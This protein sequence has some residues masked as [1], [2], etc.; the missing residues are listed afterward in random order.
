MSI[1]GSLFTA[2][3]GMS[4]QSQSLS[5][6]SDNIANA[7]T[8]GY[9]RNDA[10]FS[11]LVTNAGSATLYSSGGV[12][13]RANARIS[14]QG[15]LQQSASASDIAISGN[16]MFTVRN[17]TTD[18]NSE[19]V[20]T[21]AGSFSPDKNGQLK[22]T[23]GYYLYGWPTQPDGT[24]TV[25]E[26]AG[27][28]VPV[29]LSTLGTTSQVT[30]NAS[31]KANLDATIAGAAYPLPG[32]TAASW[33]H[34][35]TVYDSLGTPQTLRADFTKVKSPTATANGTANLSGAGGT[36]ATPVSINVTASGFGPT[37]V[38][39]STVGSLM[40]QI[41]AIVNGG[42]DH[43]AFA[44][45]NS[46]G[47][48]SI[49]GV[50]VGTPLTLTDATAG[51]LATLG[52]T[53]GPVTAPAAPTMLAATTSAPNTEG[54]W[55]VSYTDKNGTVIKNGYVNFDGTGKLN[56]APDV[57]GDV[58]VAL[59]GI[60]WGNGSAAQNINYNMADLSQ[61]SNSF[62]VGADSQDG[63]G[64]GTLSGITF[65][66]D[67]F[68]TAQYSNGLSSKAYQL[69][70]ANFPNTNGLEAV[71]GN[72]YRVTDASGNPNLGPANTG[73]AGTVQGGELEASNVDI[74][75]EFSKMIVT[76]RAYTANTKVISTADQMTQDL[77]QLR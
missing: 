15:I 69:A 28:L 35:I 47:T 51:S 42:G 39:A 64:L 22:N 61:L 10:A 16:G 4:A 46:D 18:P 2:V 14:L 70:V 54:W 38:T 75:D 49:K 36:F 68:V 74:A 66:Q 3:S 72:V 52:M 7:N 37:T 27:T 23:A 57:N 73:G 77:L 11:T 63:I 30:A 33:S 58:N 8:T 1:F 6:I 59:T 45:L 43:V 60:N 67:G 32:G 21:R 44:N 19:T 50:T 55:N 31:L 26:T 12:N 56:A 29:D 9:K 62:T 17:S 40:S 5:M 71:S 53:A 65:D 13:A 48:L 24:P 41:N 76:Q 34:D 25:A 20:Y